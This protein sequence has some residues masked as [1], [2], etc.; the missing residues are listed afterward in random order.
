MA[1]PGKGYGPTG[2]AGNNEYDRHYKWCKKYGFKPY[3]EYLAIVGPGRMGQSVYGPPNGSQ[4]QKSRH[5]S[6]C[7]SVAGMFIQWDE[8]QRRIGKAPKAEEPTF[9]RPKEE[10]IAN[11]IAKATKC[12]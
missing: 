3:P 8:Y 12:R 1:H 4:K 5:R 2:S 6:Y 11:I 10:I 7:H 9:L